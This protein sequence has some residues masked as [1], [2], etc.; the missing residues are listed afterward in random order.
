MPA[1]YLLHKTAGFTGTADL[2]DWVDFDAHPA[3]SF[4]IW[5]DDVHR[6]VH[7]DTDNYVEITKEVYDI[8]RCLNNV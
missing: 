5:R 3:R 4:E 8:M 6:F 2:P 1:K 7:T